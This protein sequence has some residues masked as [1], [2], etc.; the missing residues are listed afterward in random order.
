MTLNL[1]VVS[2]CA[3]QEGNTLLVEMTDGSIKQY[4][5]RTVL[6]NSALR[7]LRYRTP[8]QLVDMVYE[9]NKPLVKK[10]LPPSYKF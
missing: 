9:L 4:Q 2:S 7:D 5:M 1:T 10:L 6:S 8:N 3:V